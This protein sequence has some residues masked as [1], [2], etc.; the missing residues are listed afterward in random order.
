MNDRGHI[1]KVGLFVTLG[2]VVFGVL[3]IY[4]GHFQSNSYQVKVSFKNAQGLLR[5]SHVRM[6][7]VNVGEVVGVDLN[8]D[9]PLAN[10]EFPTPTVTLAIKNKYSIPI[11]ST[12]KIV[13]GILITNPQIEIT[14]SNSNDKLPKDSTASVKGLEAGGVLDALSPELS[15][16]VSNINRS[17][18]ALTDKLGSSYTKIDKILDQTHTLLKTG[19]DTILATKSLVGDPQ[20]RLKLTATLSNFEQ[21]SGE[22]RLAAKQLRVQFNGILTNGSGTLQELKESMLNLFDRLDTTLDDANA[23][24]K[25]I[26]EQV[27]D[28]RLQQSLQ[29]TADLARVTLARFNQLASDMHQFIGDPQ[30]QGDMK[31]IVTNLKN[32]TAQGEEAV[33]K[34]NSFLGKFSDN[35]PGELLRGKLPKVELLTNIS[36]RMDPERFRMDIEA[37]VNFNKNSMLN[38]GLFDLGQDTRLTFQAGQRTMNGDLLTRYGLY[39][40]KLGAG[41]EYNLTPNIQIR[42]DIYDTLHPR[43]DFRTLFRVNNNA[44]VWLGADGVGRH[45]SPIL[46]VQYKY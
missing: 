30:L 39:A 12:F 14:P 36:E 25:R 9:T 29:E 42:G 4:L 26:T 24:V 7:G 21:A 5:Q 33:S 17:F 43:L 45:S 13:S 19:T 28:P 46:G 31:Q 38:V 6:Q 3:Y 41:M 35:K 8:T 37:R 20:I 23:V 15:Q 34:V 32:A 27:T 18:T 11:N 22:A 16:A 1:I 10:G 2:C 40:S 44:F